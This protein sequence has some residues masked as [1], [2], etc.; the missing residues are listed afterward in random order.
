MAQP[1]PNPLKSLSWSKVSA[2]D[3]CPACFEKKYILRMPSPAKAV[4]ALGSG[5]H[6][7]VQTAREDL[8]AGRVVDPEAA[9]ESGIRTLRKETERAGGLMDL[10]TYK[11]IEGIEERLRLV[12]PV[13][14]RDIVGTDQDN[15]QVLLSVEEPLDFEGVFDFDFAGKYDATV[16]IWPPGGD[17]PILAAIKDLKTAGKRLSVKDRETKKLT[18]VAV[19]CDHLSQLATYAMPFLREGKEMPWLVIEVVTTTEQPVAE[20]LIEMPTAGEIAA[21]R[22]KIERVALDVRAGR[23]P[24]MPGM[25]CDYPHRLPSHFDMGRPT[26]IFEELSPE[27][28]PK[29]RARKT[30]P[31]IDAEAVPAPLAA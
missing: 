26:H 17:R 11:T 15:G 29:P 28:A 30:E 13:A 10:G 12:V 21:V 25:F 4:L 23:F 27:L 22:E 6:A 16:G 5:V 31:T 9:E 14:L 1:F 18:G 2:Y 7:A 3:R 24:E 8:I 20:R 19:S